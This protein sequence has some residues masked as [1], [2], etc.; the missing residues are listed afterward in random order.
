MRSQAGE[1]P[2]IHSDVAS[3][4]ESKLAE[5]GPTARG[6]DWKNE[7][8]QWIRFVQL[9]RVI[10]NPEEAFSIIDVGCGYGA[11]LIF[12]RE[13]FRRFDYIGF[14]IS[15]KMV[16]S[17]RALH[18]EDPAGARFTID[19]TSIQKADYVVAS[20]LFNVRLQYT[21]AD[22]LA[23]MIETLRQIDSMAQRAWAVNF[24]TIYSDAE[25][26]RNDLYYADPAFVMDWCM[27]NASRWVAVQHD[28]E[29]YEFTV[30]VRKKLD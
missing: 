23:Y 21:S 18:A 4:Y 6:V 9:T 20:G 3:Y 22:W 10:S 8:S 30:V 25:R 2:R 19:W 5:F 26:M 24:L 12:L 15:E 7:Q 17:A 27:K 1:Q 11:L 13:K 16:T 14:D 29:L 28:Y